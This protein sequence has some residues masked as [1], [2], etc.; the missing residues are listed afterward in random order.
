MFFKLSPN[1]SQCNVYFSPYSPVT[2]RKNGE[3]I[4]ESQKITLQ[5]G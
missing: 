1:Y 5:I 2:L 3:E 4:G